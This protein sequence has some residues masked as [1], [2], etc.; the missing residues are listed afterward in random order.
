MYYL[1]VISEPILILFTSIFG[2]LAGWVST[3]LFLPFSL[4]SLTSGSWLVLVLFPTSKLP[5]LEARGAASLTFAL[6]DSVSLAFSSLYFCFYS[7][8]LST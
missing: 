6:G 1:L 8:T 5:A 2:V 7:E 4:H 3:S